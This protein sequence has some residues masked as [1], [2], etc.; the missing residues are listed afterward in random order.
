MQLALEVLGPQADG[1]GHLLA[2]SHLHLG[3]W[4]RGRG[5]ADFEFPF[6]GSAAAVCRQGLPG[7]VRS[8]DLLVEIWKTS[9]ELGPLFFTGGDGFRVNW[10]GCDEIQKRSA[11]Q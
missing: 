8:V 2:V 4:T 11:R 10:G 3:E 5:G 7:S 6:A 9:D 1:E